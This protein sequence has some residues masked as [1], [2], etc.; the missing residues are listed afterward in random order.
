MSLLGFMLVIFETNVVNEVTVEGLS[1]YFFDVVVDKYSSQDNVQVLSILS[2]VLQYIKLKFPE[3][4]QLMLGSDNASCLASHDN[5]PF[6]HHLNST[7]N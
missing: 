7:I 5:I 2:C 4:V 1:Y 6:I 3:I